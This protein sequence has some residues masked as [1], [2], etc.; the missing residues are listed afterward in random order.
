MRR[1]EI[2]SL[3][4]Q[5]Y[6]SASCL[7]A[8]VVDK[9]AFLCLVGVPLPLAPVGVLQLFVIPVQDHQVAVLWGENFLVLEGP[10]S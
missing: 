8:L 3:R 2:I 10:L 6:T 4:Y 1:N 9:T 5:P 7:A